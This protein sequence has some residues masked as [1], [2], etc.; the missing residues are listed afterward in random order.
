[1]MHQVIIVQFRMKLKVFQIGHMVTK[2]F[3]IGVIVKMLLKM[4]C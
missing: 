4:R 1:M 3:R 2:K